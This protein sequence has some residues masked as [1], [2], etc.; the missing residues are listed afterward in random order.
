MMGYNLDKQKQ[1]FSVQF[2]PNFNNKVLSDENLAKMNPS[3]SE[4]T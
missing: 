3:K 4:D 1:C 2:I